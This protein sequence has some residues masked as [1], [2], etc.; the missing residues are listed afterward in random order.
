MHLASTA[1]SSSVAA[2]SPPV[3]RVLVVAGKE[4]KAFKHTYIG[5]EHLLLGLLREDEGVCARV[6]KSARVD[7]EKTRK[8][9]VRELDPNT[10]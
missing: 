5:T 7:V 3:R 8:E 2:S 4:A 6:F 1:S 9:I 10:Q